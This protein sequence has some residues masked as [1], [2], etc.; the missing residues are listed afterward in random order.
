MLL[1]F[2]IGNREL[3]LGFVKSGD[4]IA[5]ARISCSPDRTSDEYACAVKAI[6]D[7]RGISVS[8][9]SGAIG[10][11]VVPSITE[12]VK[13][14]IE[15]LLGIRVHMLGAGTKTGLNILIDDPTQ[16][17]GDLVAAAVGALSKYKPPMILVDFGIATTFSVIDKNGS[18]IGCSIVPGITL[19]SEALSAGTSLLPTVSG[20]TP[21]KCIG[22][23]TAESMQSG[24]VFGNASMVDGMIK[25]IE[26]ELGYNADVIASGGKNSDVIVHHCSTEI[27]RDDTMLML[28]LREIYKK[29]EKKKR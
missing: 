28:G 8:D 21:R 18:F 4:I 22:T 2:S 14:A 23:N 3:A 29:N 16:L 15:S 10:A 11:S 24:S 7:L 20:T 5:T 6:L 13:A 1:T 25:R 9:F 27:K 12:T 17:G 19:S 26:A